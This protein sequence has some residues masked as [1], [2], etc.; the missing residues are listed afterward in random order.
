MSEKTRTIVLLILLA[1][2]IGFIIWSQ[3]QYDQNF[4]ETLSIAQ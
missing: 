1:V 2:A 4:T 3:N